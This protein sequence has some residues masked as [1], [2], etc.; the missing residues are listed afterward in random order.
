M[1]LKAWYVS[2]YPHLC[3]PTDI[4]L[5]HQM[6]SAASQPLGRGAHQLRSIVFEGTANKVEPHVNLMLENLLNHVSATL[7]AAPRHH[8]LAEPPHYYCRAF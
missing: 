4:A 7:F 1:T 2:A 3:I 6:P 8:S 5:N